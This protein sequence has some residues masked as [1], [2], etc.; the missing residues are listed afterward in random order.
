LDAIRNLARVGASDPLAD[1]P[2]LTRAVTCGILDA[3]HLRNNPFAQGRIRTRL[4]S[5][6]CL[7]VGDD[8]QPISEAER[9]TQIEIN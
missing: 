6:A 2:T 7:A 3:P 9:L 1:P 8:G 5:R 4:I